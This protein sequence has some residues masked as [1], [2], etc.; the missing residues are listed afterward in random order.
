MTEKELQKEYYENWKKENPQRYLLWIICRVAD[1]IPVVIALFQLNGGMNDEKVTT[2]VI[3]F[4]VLIVMEILAA[5]AISS[6]RKGWKK[7]LEANKDR[8]KK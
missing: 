4:V 5:I 6:E 8:L 7:Y 2:I 1:V 3:C